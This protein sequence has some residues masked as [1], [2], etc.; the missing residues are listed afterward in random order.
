MVRA[1]RVLKRMLSRAGT[2]ISRAVLEK[3]LN[4]M[5]LY[6]VRYSLILV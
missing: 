5:A 3:L 1:E 4:L 2:Q 6:L